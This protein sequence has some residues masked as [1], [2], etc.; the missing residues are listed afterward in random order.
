[1]SSR[2][3]NPSLHDVMDP[4]EI[5]N[6]KD[7]LIPSADGR[8]GVSQKA[9]ILLTD[10][11]GSTAFYKD[12]GNLAGRIMIQKHNDLLFPIIKAHLGTVVKT[13]GDSILAYFISPQ[14]AFRASIAI[15]KKL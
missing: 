15:Q 9:A 8:G 4:T 13:M 11:Q 3:H 12:H 1:M 2:K 6:K 5:K 14:Q 10:I 7:S